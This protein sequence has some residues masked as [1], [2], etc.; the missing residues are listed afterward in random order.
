MN[1]YGFVGGFVFPILTIAIIA[2]TVCY[3]YYRWLPLGL[4]LACFFVGVPGGVCPMPFTLSLLAIFVFY[5][6]TYQTAPVFVSAL[7]SYTLVCGSGLFKMLRERAQQANTDAAGEFGTKPQ[8]DPAE[9]KKA[10]EE[11]ARAYDLALDK[12][13]NAKP[14]ADTF[15]GANV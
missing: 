4:C 5:F 15:T 14:S 12:Y 9:R 2:G 1:C 11:S 7:T 3:M 10:E 8:E 13:M 6:G